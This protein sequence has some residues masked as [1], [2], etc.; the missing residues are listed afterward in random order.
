VAEPFLP[1][2]GVRVLAWEQA[3]ALPMATRL[4]ADMG[5][6]VV[7]LES[8]GRGAPRVRHL[9][10]E[11]V[12]NKQSL[13]LD[14]TKPEARGVVLRLAAQADVLCENFTP[15]VKRQFG[16]GYA[17]LSAE[18][19]RLIMLSLSGYGQTG[20]WSERPTFGPG[21]EA[22]AGHA[23]S[24]GYPDAP[25]TRPGATFYSDNTSGFYAA[26]AIL[27]ALLRRRTSG[28]G[29]F[30]D[31]AMYEATA[32]HLGPSLTAA[33]RTRLPAE[34][35]GNANPHML[36]QDV[37]PAHGDERWLAVSVRSDQGAALAALLGV[38]PDAPLEP[39]LRAWAAERDAADAAAALQG[40]GIAA[41]AVLDARDLLRDPQLRARE[42]F[43]LVHHDAPVH[44]YA[45]HPHAAS[46]W[47]IPGRPRAPLH[48]APAVGQDSR[49]VLHAW[50]GM[51]DAEIDALAASGALGLGEG[52]P[53]RQP[54]RPT[55]A[56]LAKRRDR[57]LIAGYDPDP[58]ATLGLERADE[59]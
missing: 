47:R 49:A 23:L 18:N 28:R 9:Q 15:R 1:L 35:R 36:L 17:A 32:F 50:L 40:A 14:L 6:E 19:P 59:N 2:A 56:E 33:A 10:N 57:R 54:A 45:A 39:A 22:A 38:A 42:A 30:I 26:L 29:A 21:I 11:L 53:P 8:H 4:L 12:R 16:L 25:P 34:R 20:P 13:A 46:P 3:V 55:D 27:G 7:R 48:E 44:G 31:L 51:D 58:G 41:S 52:P 43:T 24:M 5:A 37:F